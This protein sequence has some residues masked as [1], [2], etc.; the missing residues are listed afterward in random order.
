LNEVEIP[1]QKLGARDMRGK[2]L[3]TLK[4]DDRVPVSE[5]A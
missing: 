2:L 3:K 1:K 5:G 4:E